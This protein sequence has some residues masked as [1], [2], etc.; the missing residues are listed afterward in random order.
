MQKV[1]IIGGTTFDHIVH[2]PQL[3]QPLPHTIHKADF[4]EGTGS[5]GAG[6][7]LNMHKLGIP[8]Q[9]Y[10]VLGNDVY[11]KM[12]VEYLQRNGID[13]FYDIDETGTER[14]VNL[15][16]EEGNRISIFVTQSSGQINHNTTAIQNAMDKADVL[17]LNIIAYC[18]NLVP[19]VIASGKPVWTDLHDYDGTNAYHDPFIHASQY[20]HLSSDNL[21][22]YKPVMQRLISEGKKLVI[23]THGKQGATLLTPEGEWM[24]QLAFT[25]FPLVDANG[26]GDAFFSGFLFGWLQQLPLQQCM[27]YGAVCAALCIGSRQLAAENL[28]AELLHTTA[29]KL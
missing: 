13:A 23:C 5:T 16:D 2:L 11:G 8:L 7:A 21:P 15:M 19:M 24:E 17:V 20:I 4:Y 28:S 27:Q 29:Q 10:S 25:Q 14:H 18:K 6:K 22:D 9:L 1:F 3:P 26:A 12:I